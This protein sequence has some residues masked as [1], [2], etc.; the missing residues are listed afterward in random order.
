MRSNCLKW[1][2]SPWLVQSSSDDESRIVV[3]LTN[4]HR[5]CRWTRGDFLR[6]RHLAILHETSRPEEN[7][8]LLVNA[9]DHKPMIGRPSSMAST[10]TSPEQGCHADISPARQSYP[11]VWK[12]GRPRPVPSGFSATASPSSPS[13]REGALLV[14]QIS[15]CCSDFP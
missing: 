3:R 15:T 8:T 13:P 12:A 7:Q 10:R 9:R 5:P 6:S 1:E 14:P 11:R 4:A 2:R